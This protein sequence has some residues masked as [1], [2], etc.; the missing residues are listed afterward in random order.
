MERDHCPEHSK[1]LTEVF[2]SVNDA[3]L[4]ANNFGTIFNVTSDPESAFY[5]PNFAHLDSFTGYY[6]VEIFMTGDSDTDII[7]L[8][9]YVGGTWAGVTTTNNQR[10]LLTPKSAHTDA[11]SGTENWTT[12]GKA[13]FKT[14]QPMQFLRISCANALQDSVSF[15]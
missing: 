15:R 9:V 7:S 2:D 14:K 12:I 5:N 3:T 10:M 11:V 4:F 13:N 6:E 8:D 1:V